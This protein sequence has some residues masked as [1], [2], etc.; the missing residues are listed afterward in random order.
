MGKVSM[1]KY[2]IILEALVIIAT[3]VVAMFFGP[4]FCNLVGKC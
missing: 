4:I 3:G 2:K 1:S